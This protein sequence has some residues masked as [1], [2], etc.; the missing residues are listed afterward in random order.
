MAAYAACPNTVCKISGLIQYCDSKDWTPD[1]FEGIVN[2]CI[3][4]FGESRIVFGSNWPVCDMLGS[5][6]RW[7]EALQW[8]LRDR[9][10]AFVRKFFYENAKT[11]YK[12]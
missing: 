7:L 12:I 6:N 4:V 2:Y 11:L 5:V 1:M 3:D 10:E 8:I 9:S